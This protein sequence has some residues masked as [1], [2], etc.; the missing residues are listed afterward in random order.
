MTEI[1][2]TEFKDL[3]DL[4]NASRTVSGTVVGYRYGEI[5][6][7]KN[8]AYIPISLGRGVW[9]VLF[10]RNVGPIKEDTDAIELTF[11]NEVREVNI[12]DFGEDPKSLYYLVIRPLNDDII[13][14]LLEK[15]S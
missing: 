9:Y 10:T 3:R 13:K 4:L 5:R 14:K 11:N 6:V 2:S 15:L 1:I 7:F 8:I 12:K